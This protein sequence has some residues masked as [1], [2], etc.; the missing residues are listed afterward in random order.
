MERNDAELET[1]AIGDEGELFL[2]GRE[3]TFEPGWLRSER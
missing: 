1:V 2:I 3:V